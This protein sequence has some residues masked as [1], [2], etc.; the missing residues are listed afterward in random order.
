MF[1][2]EIELYQVCNMGYYLFVATIE[3]YEITSDKPKVQG[4]HRRALQ[5][6]YKSDE[7]GV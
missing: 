6:E 3:I 2:L 5:Q 4:V 1:K 7:R